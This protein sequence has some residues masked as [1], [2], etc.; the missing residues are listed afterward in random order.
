MSMKIGNGEAMSETMFPD[1]FSPAVNFVTYSELPEPL[2]RQRQKGRPLPVEA[3]GAL[4]A[5]VEA[6]AQLTNAPIEIA[7]QSVLAMASL[8][9]Q[10]ICNV[11]T[12]AGD[13]PLSLF[14]LTIAASGERKSSCDRLASKP[15][16][17]WEEEMGLKYQDMLKAYEFELAVYENMKRLALKARC[18]EDSVVDGRVPLAPVPPVVWRKLLADIT[19]E[20]LL[21]HFEEGDPSVGIFADEGGQFFGGHDMGRDNQLK[22]AAGLSKVWDG[23]PLNR[24]R[25]GSPQVTFRNRRGALHLMIQ[26]RIAE[27]VLRNEVLRDQGLLSRMLIAWPES[28]IGH[29]LIVVSDD[30][31][32]K[33]RQA[34]SDLAVF[35]SHLTA[36]LNQPVQTGASA[37]ELA[38]RRLPLDPDAKSLLIRFA[39]KI[40]IEQAPSAAL[41]HITGFASK[42][43][44]QAARIAGVLAIFEDPEAA[45]LSLRHMEQGVLLTSWYVAEAQRLLD[46]GPVDDTLAQ[47]QLLLDWLKE[48]FPD[49]L[50]DKRTIV[51]RGPGSVRDTKTVE[52]LIRI[53]VLN[54]HIHA[55]PTGAKIGD[56][57]A[58]QAWELNRHA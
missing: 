7:F 39:N 3:L 54:R 16:L 55:L 4:K 32:E 50:F 13:A 33:R 47:A 17:D 24:T 21:R 44:E 20:G 2:L 18:D 52:R 46:A 6:I 56:H 41:S 30:E 8:V 38:P 40:E 42:A 19:F 57:H 14:L 58:K 45:S 29:R 25:A 49:Q 9:A 1:Q 27:E 15:L 31:A 5:P 43:P 48:R 51:R 34:E 23:A 37:L 10:Q 22:T 28:K 36:R 12:L 35:H 26:P 53:L 11:E